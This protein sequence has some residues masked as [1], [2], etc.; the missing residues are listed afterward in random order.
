ML[1]TITSSCIG[2]VGTTALFEEQGLHSPMEEG[3]DSTTSRG[4]VGMKL[5]SDD[6]EE[7]FS[8][9]IGPLDLSLEDQK[10]QLP[11][12]IAEEKRQPTMDATITAADVLCGRGKMSFN[13]GR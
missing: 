7:S 6:D 1:N 11:S 13:H 8:Q 10:I 2:T 5:N 3:Y 4:S 12:I 9:S